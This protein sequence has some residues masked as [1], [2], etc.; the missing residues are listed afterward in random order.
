MP[1]STATARTPYYV[2]LE[3][4]S[5]IGPTVVQEDLGIECLPIY[6]FSDK[7]PYDKFCLNSELAL[8][9]YP[10]VKRYLRE[11]AAGDGLKLVV[12]D[13]GGPREPCLLAAT[14]EVVLKAQETRKTH[15]PVEYRLLFDQEANAYTVVVE[16]DTGELRAE[17]SNA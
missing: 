4:K 1:I 14:M 15:V 3:E 5:R 8:K 2:L 10:L 17:V 13:A 11:Q 7:S 6:G 12:F 9:P 16:S